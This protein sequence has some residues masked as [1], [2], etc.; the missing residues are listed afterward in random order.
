MDTHTRKPEQTPA[1]ID[2][3]AAFL[4]IF[5]EKIPTRIAPHGAAKKIPLKVSIVS[6]ETF[7]REMEVSAQN[8]ASSKVTILPNFNLS[9]SFAL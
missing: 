6:R 8:N 9:A 2:I 1:I 3:Q 7:S 5:L 4:I